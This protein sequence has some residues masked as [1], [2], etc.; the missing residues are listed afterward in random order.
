MG[1][2]IFLAVTARHRSGSACCNLLLTFLA[3][4]FESSSLF[5]PVHTCS[6][7]TTW[8]V[9]P[10][11][12]LMFAKR[13]VR[14]FLRTILPEAKMRAVVLGS[15]ILMITAAKRCTSRSS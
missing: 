3:A 11:L 14:R 7:S 1:G 8:N 15:R 4:I 6:Q 5:A 13:C 2:K 10:I 9:Y 12:C